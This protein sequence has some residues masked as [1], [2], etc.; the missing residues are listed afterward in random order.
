MIKKVFIDPSIIS[1]MSRTLWR[2]WMPGQV[3]SVH[4]EVR[5]SLV[6]VVMG[7]LFRGASGVDMDGATSWLTDMVRVTI[8]S[9]SRLLGD[10]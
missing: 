3:G 6:Y 5:E 8:A 9:I 4:K 7:C 2:L 1:E 10:L